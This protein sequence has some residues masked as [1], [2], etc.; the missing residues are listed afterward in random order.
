MTENILY[1]IWRSNLPEGK[2][3]F[4]SIFAAPRKLFNSVTASA[5]MAQYSLFA[6]LDQFY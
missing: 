6:I 3:A 5:M 1:I 2:Y 4:W